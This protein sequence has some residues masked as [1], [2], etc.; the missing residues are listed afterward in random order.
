MNKKLDDATRKLSEWGVERKNLLLQK[1]EF[2]KDLNIIKAVMN[3]N[4]ERGKE[5]NE[6]YEVK[7]R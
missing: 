6:S 7:L 3:E 4:A 5:I 2:E 1:E